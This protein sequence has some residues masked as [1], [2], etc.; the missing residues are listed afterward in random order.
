MASH[1]GDAVTLDGGVGGQR[2]MSVGLGSGPHGDSER[3]EGH[4]LLRAGVLHVHVACL[5][6]WNMVRADEASLAAMDDDG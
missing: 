4:P 5:A 2:W 3:G 1:G 6:P